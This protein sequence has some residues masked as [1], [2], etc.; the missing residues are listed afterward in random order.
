MAQRNEDGETYY[1]F[2]FI[3][4]APNFTRHALGV[5]S[6]GN[7]MCGSLTDLLKK[8]VCR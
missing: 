7:G 5:I 6:I 3:A 4:Q 2:E 1:T 8:R